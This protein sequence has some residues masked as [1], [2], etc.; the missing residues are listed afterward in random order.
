MKI[1]S[2]YLGYECVSDFVMYWTFEDEM[3]SCFSWRDYLVLTTLRT[4]A[5]V[6]FANSVQVYIEQEVTTSYL[7]YYA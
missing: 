1:C 7:Q 6:G 2:S 4:F 3:V 5:G